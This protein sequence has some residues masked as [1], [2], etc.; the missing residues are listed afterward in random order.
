VTSTVAVTAIN[1][2]PT[3]AADTVISNTSSLF[4]IFKQALLWND[5][6]AEGSSLSIAAVNNLGGSN[7]TAELVDGDVT[8]TAA[9]GATSGQFTYTVSDGSVTSSAAT[10]S[11]TIGSG[12]LFPAG[13]PTKF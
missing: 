6:D 10:V 1:D 7:G 8:F 2:T 13:L 4:T 9:S 11:L 5:S 3:A 12:P